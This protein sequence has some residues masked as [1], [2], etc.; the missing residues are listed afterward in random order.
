MRNKQWTDCP[1]CGSKGSMELKTGL[2]E[3]RKPKDYPPFE[4]KDLEGHFCRVCGDG[5]WTRASERIIEAESARHRAKHD[6][7]RV[8]PSELMSVTDAAKALEVSTKAVHQMM[9]RGSIKYV[10][11]A[12]LRLPIRKHLIGRK[13]SAVRTPATTRIKGARRTDASKKKADVR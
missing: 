9:D 8:F 6:A 11:V 10:Y 7:G 4:V 1:I 3:R 5:F 13:P 2:V 12:N